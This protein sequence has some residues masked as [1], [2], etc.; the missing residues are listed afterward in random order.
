MWAP[1]E[2]QSKTNSLK[3]ENMYFFYMMFWSD[4]Y[5]ETDEAVRA[6]MP[7]TWKKPEGVE[8]IELW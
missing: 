7:T 5:N 8:W 1:E 6:E 2:N 4:Y 3:E